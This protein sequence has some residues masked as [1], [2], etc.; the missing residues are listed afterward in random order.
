MIVQRSK[1]PSLDHLVGAQQRWRHVEA[2]RGLT[3]HIP[4]LV[5]TIAME[6]QRY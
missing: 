4:K 6:I 1:S 2:E 5:G 3:V